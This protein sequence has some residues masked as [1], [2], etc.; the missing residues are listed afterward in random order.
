MGKH[1]EHEKDRTVP[2]TNEEPNPI[3]KSTC[4]CGDYALSISE[5]L[6]EKILAKH[7]K[8]PL[9]SMMQIVLD[10]GDYV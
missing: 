6:A 9:R 1:H 10:G 4:T 7:L 3:W 2:S 5:D 8:N